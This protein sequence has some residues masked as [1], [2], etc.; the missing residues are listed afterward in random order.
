M[1][2][3]QFFI[4]ISVVLCLLGIYQELRRIAN[5]LKEQKQ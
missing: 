5:L 1:G 3:T 4:G 2:I